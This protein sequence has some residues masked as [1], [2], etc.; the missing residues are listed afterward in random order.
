LEVLKKAGTSKTLLFL[1]IFTL[2]YLSLLYF[3]S[4]YFTLQIFTI[5]IKEFIIQDEAII[6]K[7]VEK[8][9]SGL[10]WQMVIIAVRGQKAQSY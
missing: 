9:I 10:S 8:M 1:L 6:A 7:F 3:T 2:F 4:L 5:V